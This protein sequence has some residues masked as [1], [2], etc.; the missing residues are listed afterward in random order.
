MLGTFYSI[1]ASMEHTM[2]DFSVRFFGSIFSVILGRREACELHSCPHGSAVFIFHPFCVLGPFLGSSWGI[3]K[4]SWAVLAHLG[5]ILGRRG[6]V[7][8]PSKGVLGHLVANLAS[9]KPPSGRPNTLFFLSFF[10]TFL[11]FLLSK[12]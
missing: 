10:Q 6:R 9:L 7:L 5:C 8:V 1:W 3:L 11:K 4:P 2:S 12:I